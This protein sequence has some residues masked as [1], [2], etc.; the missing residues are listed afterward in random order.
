MSKPSESETKPIASAKRRAQQQIAGLRYRIP[1]LLIDALVA[2]P[3][4][5]LGYAFGIFDGRIF[6]VPAGW[7]WSEWLLGF[8]LDERHVILAPMGGWL[9]LSIAIASASEALCARSIGGRIL[10]LVVTDKSGFK[11]GP[12][13]A[14]RRALGAVLNSLALGLGYLWIWVSSSR[15]GWHDG[16]S[17]TVVLR[18][19]VGEAPKDTL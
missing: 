1:A 16:V 3:F 9:L 5:A 8:W 7:F 11:I 10:G 19:R 12:N 17:G 14:I 6:K 18:G 13:L 15:R 2:L 4:I